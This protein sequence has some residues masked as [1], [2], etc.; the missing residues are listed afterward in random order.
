MEFCFIISTLDCFI[1]KY[2]VIVQTLMFDLFK[3]CVYLQN[4]GFNW[5]D[6]YCTLVKFFLDLNI[7]VDIYQSCSNISFKK[8]FKL[9]RFNN[10]NVLL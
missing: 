2:Y 10:E 8:E 5:K 1:Y 9:A 4:Q 6:I 7:Y 3:I